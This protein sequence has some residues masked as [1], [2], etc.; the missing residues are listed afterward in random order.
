M[1]SRILAVHVLVTMFSMVL[2]SRSST[3]SDSGIGKVC[4]MIVQ[5][6]TLKKGA[7]LV[8]GTS[9]AKVILSVLLIKIVVTYKMLGGRL[10]LLSIVR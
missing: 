10:V 1:P 4:T 2:Y 3:C 6:G 7:A 9:W 5:R 8:A